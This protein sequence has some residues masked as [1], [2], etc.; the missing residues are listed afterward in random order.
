MSGLFQDDPPTG[1]DA[2]DALPPPPAPSSPGLF[3]DALPEAPVPAPAATPYRVLARKYRPTS[4]A[5]MVG[6]EAMVRTLRNAFAMG[7]VAHAFMLTGVRGVGKTTTARIIARALNCTGPD[8]TGGPTADPCGVCPDC[9]AI[10]ADRH[11]DVQEMDAAS[12]T[13]VEDVR[14]IIEATRFRPMQARAKVFI[15]DEVHMLSRNAFN[16]LLKTLEEPPPHV[17]FVFA[18]T[19]IRKVPVT[20]LSRCQRFDLR[21]IGTAELAAHFARIAEKEGV[22]ADP[23][24]LALIAR[25]ADGSARDGLSLLDQAIAQGQPDVP[26][27]AAAVADMLGLADRA[28]VFDL[29]EAVMAGRPAEV[30]AITDRAHAHG[31]DLGVLLQ[32]LLELVHTLTR[33]RAVPALRDSPDLPEAER[34]RGTALAEH[35]SM[36]TL[37]RAWQMLLKGIA[38][39]EA[40]PD[41]RAAAEMV[42][43]RLCYVAELPPPGEL[44]RRLT[45]TPPAGGPGP[46]VPQGGHGG[47][48]A[49]ANGGMVGATVPAGAP[50][51]ASFRDVAA[52]VAE[53]QDIML[54]AHLVHSMHLVRFAPPVIELRPEPDA[55]RDLAARLGALLTEVTGTRWTIAL[56]TTEG[57]PTLGEQGSAAEA[58]RRS[59]AA[60]HPLVRAILETFPG[61]R[62]EAVH[63]TR[64]DAYGLTAQ[65]PAAEPVLGGEAEFTD[66]LEFAPADAGFADGPPEEWET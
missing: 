23:E 35:L 13:G 43:I 27:S 17:K 2:P 4:F 52:L 30:L 14:E 16:A 65:D 37:G 9:Q 48:R 66:D 56:S 28:A 33:L 54:H 1:Q 15:I 7:R 36:A 5:D 29:F 59:A 38:E 57:E 10:L 24:A 53:R 51:L 25:A 12:R 41:R 42:L 31:A 6:Q 19:E 18:T 44:V 49:V 62:I 21:R 46:G 26:I 55:P 11:P 45:E 60:A 61:A 39:V 8:G 64:A 47:V 22:A 40:A 3:G 58:A 50:R 20:V 63:D 34:T 32:D